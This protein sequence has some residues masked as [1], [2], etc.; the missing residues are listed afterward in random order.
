MDKNKIISI[1]IAIIV[2]VG[3]GAFYGGM[4]YAENKAASDRQ[5]RI[6]QFGGSRTEF[7]SGG[8]GNRAAGGF[9]SGEI[10]LKDSKSITVKLRD[11]GSKIIFY[12]DATEI[13]K[14][15]KGTFSDLEIGKNV[16]VNGAANP[17]GSISAESIQLR[18]QQ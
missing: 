15:I 10:I 17:D 1:G 18:P 6:Q 8:S 9:T 11:G 16:S 3:G 5:Q 2:T 13:G 4:K 14:F 12:S 7:R